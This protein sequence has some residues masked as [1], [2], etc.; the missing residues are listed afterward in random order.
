MTAWENE[1]ASHKANLTSQTAGRRSATQR[2]VFW[3]KDRGNPWNSWRKSL[4]DEPSRG[5]F[6]FIQGSE[7]LSVPAAIS[8]AASELQSIP[9]EDDVFAENLPWNRLQEVG[10]PVQ[11]SEN[12]A[13]AGPPPVVAAE[14][15][16]TGDRL[17]E[18]VAE[19]FR[20]PS[21][22]EFSSANLDGSH[23]DSSSEQGGVPGSLIPPE[24]PV[25][26]IASPEPTVTALW[27]LSALLFV[28]RRNVRTTKR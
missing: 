8:E 9:I 27:G 20:R 13:M 10:S 15:R 22:L 3:L 16:A 6:D 5:D 7:T 18:S 26:L 12:G 25:P 2:F 4:P 11:F 17:D 24:G 14:A 28:C 1:S 21:K 23:S 19:T